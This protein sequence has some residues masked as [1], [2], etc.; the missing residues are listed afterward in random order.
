MSFAAAV[1]GFWDQASGS[2]GLGWSLGG[3]EGGVLLADGELSA[4]NAELEVAQNGSASLRLEGDGGSAEAALSSGPAPA[5]L[6]AEAAPDAAAMPGQPHASVCEASVNFGGQS[7]SCTGHLTTWSEDPLAGAG[8]L[9]H[10]ALPA[11]DGALLVA[12]AWAPEG[13]GTHAEETGAAW[14]LDAEGR[15]GAYPHAFL[16]TQYDDDG[17]QT[18]AG[19]ELWSADAEA[20]PVRG[21]GTAAGAPPAASVPASPGHFSGAILRSSVEGHEGLGSYLIWRG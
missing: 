5:P 4:A 12:L 11:A 13:V 19:L 3:S 16:S 8:I 7:S 18:R 20:P 10:L 14:L 2:A 17:R 6:E 15:A 9:R 1:C 21:A